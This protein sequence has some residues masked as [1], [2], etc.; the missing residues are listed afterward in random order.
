MSRFVIEFR[1]G[2]T[3]E[4]TCE[5]FAESDSLEAYEFCDGN[6]GT[7]TQKFILLVPIANVNFIECLE[8]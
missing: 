3:K 7:A 1:D 4:V 2:S 6:R 5:H 8:D